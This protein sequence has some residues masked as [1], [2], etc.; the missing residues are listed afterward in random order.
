MPELNFQAVFWGW[1]IVGVIYFIRGT[2]AG[3]TASLIGG[4]ALIILSFMIV[5]GLKLTLIA[6]GIIVAIHVLIKFGW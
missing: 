6:L 2:R 5:S 1:A 3:E 4:A